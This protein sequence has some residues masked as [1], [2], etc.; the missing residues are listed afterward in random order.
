MAIFS[1]QA[2]LTYLD[3]E[4]NSNVV[5]GELLDV[6]S[7][8]KA[9]LSGTY[10]PG[11]KITYIVSVINTGDSPFGALCLSD[12]L[13]A[14]TFEGASIVP[15]SYVEG[16]LRLYVNGIL[17]P[18]PE[19]SS[20]SCLLISDLSIP[21]GGNLLLIYDAAV[22]ASAPLAEGSTIT[23]TVRFS[24]CGVSTPLTASETVSVENG[25]FLTISKSLFPLSVTENGQLTYTFVIQNTGNADAEVTDNVVITDTFDPALSDIAVTL[26]GAPLSS[27]EDYTYNPLTGGF[28]TREGKITVPAATFARDMET[29]RFVMTPGVAVVQVTGTI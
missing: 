5:T 29:G 16:S 18:L 10:R 23:N 13:G 24:G 6:L 3:T 15:L 21:A 14:Y 9:A 11:G 28:T 12:N 20:D 2:T 4:T 7:I 17:S 8:T 25:A 19:I 1:N 22:N 26:N 27:P